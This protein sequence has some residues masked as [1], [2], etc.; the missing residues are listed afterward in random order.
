MISLVVQ[1][2]FPTSLPINC[3]LS[4]D[5]SLIALYP[6]TGQIIYISILNSRSRCFSYKMKLP[7]LAVQDLFWGCVLQTLEKCEAGQMLGSE[8][9]PW[10][11]KY[12]CPETPGGHLARW[13]ALLWLIQMPGSSYTQAAVSPGPL[14][15]QPFVSTQKTNIMKSLCDPSYNQSILL[16]EKSSTF[17]RSKITYEKFPNQ[18]I[19]IIPWY[20]RR[21][22]SRTPCRYQN[23]QMLKSYI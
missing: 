12:W 19:S 23:L 13:G 17:L 10:L 9:F 6:D 20:S 22:G 11:T 5:P 8:L 21:I 4:Q 15:P 3:R 16:K 7:I 18:V 2:K 14:L 1:G